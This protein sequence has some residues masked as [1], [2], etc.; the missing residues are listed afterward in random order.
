MFKQEEHSNNEMTDFQNLG[1]K[2]TEWISET[3]SQRMASSPHFNSTP[4]KESEKKN[5]KMADE[6]TKLNDSSDDI[7]KHPLSS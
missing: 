6:K 3:I 1:T 7:F 5:Y 2:V 4:T